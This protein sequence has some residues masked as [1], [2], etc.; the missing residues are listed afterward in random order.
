M[1][2]ELKKQ[3]PQISDPIQFAKAVKII[4]APKP[5]PVKKESEPKKPLIDTNF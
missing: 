2:K 5:Q 3:V 1:T 4:R